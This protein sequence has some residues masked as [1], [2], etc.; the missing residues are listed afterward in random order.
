MPGKYVRFLLGLLFQKP[1][2]FLSYARKAL[3]G[4][5]IDLMGHRFSQM[6]NVN[7]YAKLP[8]GL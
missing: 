7:R 2:F 3:R 4:I 6:M 1:F 8:L 5:D